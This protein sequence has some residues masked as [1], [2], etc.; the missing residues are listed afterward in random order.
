MTR[1]DTKGAQET[2][3]TTSG[4][5]S[6][7]VSKLSS[8]SSACIAVRYDFR[9]S[10][11]S[12]PAL[13]RTPRAWAI[14]G[15]EQRRVADAR[16]VDEP[17]TV[18]VLVLRERPATSIASRLL[19]IPPGPVSVSSRT[20]RQQRADLGDLALPADEPVP[21]RG[22]PRPRPGPRPTPVAVGRRSD[23]S[24]PAASRR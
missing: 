3:S 13:S 18:G 16:Q 22:D 21:R 7:T 1:I 17:G 9:L 10:T 23:R 20:P 15:R 11:G 6:V 12:A 14:V 2:R 5:A 19:P 4:A 24:R 8:S